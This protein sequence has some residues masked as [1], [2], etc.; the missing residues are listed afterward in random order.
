MKCPNRASHRFTW[1]GREESFVC[2]GHSDKVRNIADA[3]GFL[4]QLH[5]IHESD[6]DGK[7]CQQELSIT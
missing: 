5:P 3:M 1:P 6:F 4:C 2:M 7:M